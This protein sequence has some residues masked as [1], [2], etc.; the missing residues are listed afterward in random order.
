MFF[1][2]FD[3]DLCAAIPSSEVVS[4]LECFNSF[5]LCLKLIL[6]VG[7]NSLNFLDIKMKIKDNLLTFDWYHKP[8]FFSRFLNFFSNH[9]IILEKGC[10]H[11]FDG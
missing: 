9:L 8:N 4:F 7:D 3:E 11:Q 1:L 6:K 5:H 2:I 10:N